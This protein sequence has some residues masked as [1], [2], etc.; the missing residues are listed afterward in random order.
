MQQ[1]RGHVNASE[2]HEIKLKLT[3][4]R[5]TPRDI[6]AMTAEQFEIVCKRARNFH[7][8]LLFLPSCSTACTVNIISNWKWVQTSEWDHDESA[9]AVMVWPPACVCGL[10]MWNSFI[11]FDFK[12]MNREDDQSSTY[13][14][15]KAAR[16]KFNFNWTQHSLESTFDLIEIE[17]DISSSYKRVYTPC[18]YV[19][20]RWKMKNSALLFLYFKIRR[21]L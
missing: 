14:R 8:F 1:R 6:E 5:A 12:L 20:T 4:A 19:Q 3:S 2:P 7:S 13:T 21:R 15:A 10:W 16:M 9:V 18:A 11:D 17:E